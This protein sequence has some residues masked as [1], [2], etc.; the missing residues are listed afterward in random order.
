MRPMVNRLAREARGEYLMRMD[1]HCMVDEGIDAK[2]IEVLEK[3][4]L[5]TAVAMRYELNPRRWQRRERTD[6]PYRR[7]SHVSE[8]GKGLRSLPWPEWEKDHRDEI[9]GETMTCSGSS[10]T[11]KRST[12][13]DRW[14]GFDERHGTF[15]Q[16]GV[17]ISCMTWLS[18]GRFLVHKGTWYAH[19]NRG[20]STYALGPHQK[21]KSIDHSHWLW[22][23]NNWPHAR[24]SF[25]WL[26]EK[27]KPPGWPLPKESGGIPALRQRS[28]IKSSR[29]LTVEDLWR[30]RDSIADPGKKHRLDV[31]WKVFDAFVRGDDHDPAVVEPYRNYLLSHLSRDPGHKPLG[32]ELRRVEQTLIDSRKLAESIA[33]E[34]LR[35]PIEFYVE[36]GRIIL[37]KGYRRLVIAHA[38]GIK[39]IVGRQF[40]NRTVAGKLS[41]QMKLTRLDGPVITDLHKLAE[42]QFCK[43]GVASSDKYFTHYYTRYYDLHLQPIRKRAKKVLELGLLRGASLALWRAYFPRA[44]LVGVDYDPEKWKKF[45]G[46]LKNCTVMIGDETD[47]VFMQKVRK[48]GP[49]DLIVDDASH[50]PDI[51]RKTFEFLWPAVRQYGYYVIEDVWRGYDGREP[52][53]GPALPPGWESRIYQ[54]QDVLSVHHYYSITFVQKAI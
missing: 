46:R 21:P 41:P 22:V 14:G 18:G 7:L 28:F 35:A 12:F 5:A 52:G 11:C 31:F 38:L 50:D 6:V 37:W 23:E 20:H 32:Y 10:W 54:E 15:G 53:K 34:G 51:Q 49:Y 8:D 30:H 33:R 36:N 17:E 2:L 24:Y 44:R 25:E 39:N 19:H 29:R 40:K 9:V 13:V 26:L 48:A 1:A 4:D 16:E 42:D 47:Q 43:Y 3:E 27:F 45:A